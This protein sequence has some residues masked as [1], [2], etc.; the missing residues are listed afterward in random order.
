M[1]NNFY[2]YEYAYTGWGFVKV[3]ERSIMGFSVVKR[4]NSL[5]HMSLIYQYIVFYF[6]NNHIPCT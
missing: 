2:F 3:K 1:Q 4:N 5:S 6:L